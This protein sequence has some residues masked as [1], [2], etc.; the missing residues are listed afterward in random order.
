[1]YTFSLTLTLSSRQQQPDYPQSSTFSLTPCPVLSSTWHIHFSEAAR[2]QALLPL[3]WAP[4]VHWFCREFLGNGR[5]LQM[6]LSVPPLLHLANILLCWALLHSAVTV[7]CQGVL[8]LPLTKHWLDF[9]E[10]L[11]LPSFCCSILRYTATF[12]QFHS[13]IKHIIL[14]A[15]L[16]VGRP[17]TVWSLCCALIRYCY[18]IASQVKVTYQLK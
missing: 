1:M 14:S 7:C 5:L 9:S 16:T 3:T 10:C 17:M 8:C 6:I 4:R 18:G 15:I 2:V 13:K 11:S 12:L